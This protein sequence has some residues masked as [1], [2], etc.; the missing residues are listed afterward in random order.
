MHQ[1]WL[2]RVFPSVVIFVCEKHIAI[3]KCKIKHSVDAF[4]HDFLILLCQ[5]QF[6]L[7]FSLHIIVFSESQELGTEYLDR[8]LNASCFIMDGGNSLDV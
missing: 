2:T 5:F 8:V 4:G 1:A 7:P 6:C 3:P